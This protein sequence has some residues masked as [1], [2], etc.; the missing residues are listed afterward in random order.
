MSLPRVGKFSQSATLTWSDASLFDGFILVGLVP[1]TSG[2]DWSSIALSGYYP[3]QRVPTFARVPIKDGKYNSNSGLF[4]TAD[5]EPPNTRY[6]CWFYDNTGRQVAGP[7]AQFQVTADP[8]TPPT[9]TLTVPSVGA[10]TP[11]PDT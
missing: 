8:V 4:F 11:T 3:T 7:S 1:P 2:T 6:V 10:T 9:P 5:L